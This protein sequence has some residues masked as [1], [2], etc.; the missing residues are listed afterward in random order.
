[1][2]LRFIF[3]RAPI[4][5]MNIQ[6]TMQSVP[7]NVIICSASVNL[8]AAAIRFGGYFMLKLEGREKRAT[9]IRACCFALLSSIALLA[10]V[11]FEVFK[12]THTFGDCSIDAN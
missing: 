2:P 11:P 6:T 1:M 7:Y 10:V 4:T 12:G 3:F 5:Q 9:M 8:M